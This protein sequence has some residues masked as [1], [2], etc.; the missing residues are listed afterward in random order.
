MDKE[1]DSVR[2]ELTQRELEM[3][4]ARQHHEAEVE[5]LKEKSIHHEQEV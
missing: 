2:V 4:Q 5:K 1:L 3:V